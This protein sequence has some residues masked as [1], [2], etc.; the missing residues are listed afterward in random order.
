MAPKQTGLVVGSECTQTLVWV[1]Q[2]ATLL[3]G[4]AKTGN[5]LRQPAQEE[6][7]VSGPDVHFSSHRVITGC[8]AL[9][10]WAR[11]GP[12]TQLVCG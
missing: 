10:S 1:C 5:F 7:V 12:S 2:P 3:L 8:S 9:G 11:G 4:L 6:A